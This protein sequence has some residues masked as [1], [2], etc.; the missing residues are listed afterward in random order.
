MSTKIH[1]LVAVEKTK[2]QAYAAMVTETMNTFTKKENLF[3]THTKTYEPIKEDDR[4]RPADNESP[5]PITTVKAKL[6]YFQKYLSGIMDVVLQKEEA[7]TRSKAD[8]LLFGEDTDEVNVLAT[9]VPVSALV[10]IENILDQVRKEVYDNIPTLD[11]A[12]KWTIDEAVGDGTYK[13]DE[14]IRQSGKK[15]AK[16]VVLYPATDKHPAQVQL[17]QEDIIVGNWTTVH[18]SGKI[19]PAEKSNVLARIDNLIDAVKKARARANNTE[20]DSSKK[21]GKT[22][23]EYINNGVL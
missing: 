17:I 11:P 21:I 5:Q 3:Q 16:P 10:Q 2:K 12:K 14:M 13:S 23:I 8:I 18:F 20:I 6:D 7:N 1:E 19:T 4:E 15:I 9:N 22:L